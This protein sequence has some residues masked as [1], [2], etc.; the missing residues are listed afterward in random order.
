[1]KKN[2]PL[3]FALLILIIGI[4]LAGCT[5]APQPPAA[6]QPAAEE[7]AAEEPAA[8]GQTQEPVELVVWVFTYQPYVDAVNDL[9]KGFNESHP[10][11]RA[12]SEVL[13]FD[14]YWGKLVTGVATN[15]GPD[16]QWAYTGS[17]LSFVSQ[18]AYQ[19]LPA[20]VIDFDKMA[21]LV[22]DTK[23][24]GKYWIVPLGVRADAYYY[25]PDYF[26]QAG[27]SPPTTWEEDL[28]VTHALTERDDNGNII[29]FGQWV[30]PTFQGYNHFKIR[31]HQAGG[32]HMSEDLRTI[33][34]DSPGCLEWMGH[35]T[36]MIK[37]STI[38]VDG[39]FDTWQSAYAEGAVGYLQG[40][41]SLIGGL[42]EMTI[43]YEVAPISAG[44]ANDETLATFWG[45]AITSQV[46]GEKVAAAEAFLQYVTSPEGNRTWARHTGDIPALLDVAAEEEFSGG[47]Y[48]A[49][50]EMLPKA[51][52]LFDFDQN[53][54]QAAFFEVIDKIVLEDAD[55]AEA[56]GEIQQEVQENLDEF[57]EN[58][59][60]QGLFE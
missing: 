46:T 41:S 4:L 60:K 44:P 20:E 6:E 12:T 34:W 21:P 18:G 51:R 9:I 40:P 16:I 48:G 2:R 22:E 49:F 33:T 1:M 13:D 37:D 59:E 11:Y 8:E 31:C 45:P 32:S 57:W 56:L 54:N 52:I 39:V 42:N 47:S 10:Q 25:Q 36:K 17:Y 7:A 5:V 55:P 53:L 19:P 26:E 30:Q 29:R 38:W 28:E 43:P 27:V 35:Y 14:Q 3:C 58:V 50:T 24:A 23:F 15:T